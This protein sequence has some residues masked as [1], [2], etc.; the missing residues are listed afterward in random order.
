MNGKTCFLRNRISTSTIEALNVADGLVESDVIGSYD[1]PNGVLTLN[2]FAGSLISGEFMKI[3]ATPANESVINPTR[4]NILK[5][6]N[7]ASIARAVLT[8]TL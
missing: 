8:D 4:N 6:D 5:F 2:A 7:E 3:V 1:A